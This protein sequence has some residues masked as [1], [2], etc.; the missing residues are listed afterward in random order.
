MEVRSGMFIGH[1]ATQKVLTEM[2]DEMK[3]MQMVRYTIS[4]SIMIDL[5]EL[6]IFLS[7][8]REII[9]R[10]SAKPA[11]FIKK[12]IVSLIDELNTIYEHQIEEELAEDSD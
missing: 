2:V 8:K 5:L 11:N 10:T 3:S 9:D 4:R 1:E 6:T 12:A 7:N